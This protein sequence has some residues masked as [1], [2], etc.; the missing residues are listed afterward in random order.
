MYSFVRETGLSRVADSS[1][2]SHWRLLTF[3]K[4]ERPCI[5]AARSLQRSNVAPLDFNAE[6]DVAGCAR[7][8]REREVSALRISVGVQSIW[9]AVRVRQAGFRLAGLL[10]P[11][12]LLVAFLRIPRFLPFISWV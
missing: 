12:R 3:R 6:V 2:H 1:D 11:D 8:E 7:R 10:L 9:G 5:L 4:R